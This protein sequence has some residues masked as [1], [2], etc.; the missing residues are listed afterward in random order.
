MKVK[1]VLKNDDMWSTGLKAL[2]ARE[3]QIVDEDDEADVII[4]DVVPAP[5]AGK[6][7]HILLLANDNASFMALQR[8]IVGGLIPPDVSAEELLVAVRTVADGRIF[9]HSRMSVKFLLMR[10]PLFRRPET[11]TPREKDVLRL[12]IR[13]YTNRETAQEL[14]IS[15]RTVESHRAN[16]YDKLHVTNRRELVEYAE[17]NGYMT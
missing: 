15:I 1:L 13:G 17:V 3:A 2:L 11:L 7:R 16:M 6:D 5:D 8:G 12:V 14:N 9:I 4:Q 10:W